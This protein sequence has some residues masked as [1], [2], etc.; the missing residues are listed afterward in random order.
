MTTGGNRVSAQP[1]SS[2]RAGPPPCQESQSAAY[3]PLVRDQLVV[4]AE[5]G[6]PAVL[7]DRD[8]VGVVGG[9]QAVRDRD[10]RPALEHRGQRAL[11]VAGGARV[12]QR[13][14]LVE[15]QRV[16]VGEDQR[17]SAS[18]C[19]CGGDRMRPP[20][21]TTVSRPSGSASTHVER[22]DGIERARELAR[23][24]PPAGPAGR[25]PRSCRRR[26]GA[27]G[28]PARR[29]RA[30]RPAGARPAGRRR[31]STGR[32][33]AVDAREQPAERRLARAGGPDHRQPL[34]GHRSRSRP[35]S[36]SRPSRYA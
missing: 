29:A 12:E 10:D 3:A 23:R 31:R 14:R 9:V 32:C 4:G 36:T 22:V 6:E 27:P 25:C 17:A 20:A 35:C 1:S 8:A 33:A 26:R 7:D 13:G 15:D 24:S 34:A 19:A 18:C 5:L 11:Q 30:G 21:P 28:S 2:S 16:R